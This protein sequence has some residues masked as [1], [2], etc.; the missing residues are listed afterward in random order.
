MKQYSFSKAEHLCG[1]K[2]T[3]RLFAEGQATIAYPFRMV[4]LL[5]PKEDEIPVKVLI[6]VPKKRFKRAVHRNRI[7]RLI[8][9]SYRLNK[10]ILTN[11]IADKDNQLYLSFQYVADEIFPFEK[12]ERKMVQALQKIRQNIEDK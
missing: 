6:S 4:Y 11:V 1:D 2:K 3:G 10:H 12:T 5:I 9:E 7:K 8:R